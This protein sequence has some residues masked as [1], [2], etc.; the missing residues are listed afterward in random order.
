MG[1]RA[2]RE[3]TSGEHS[4]VCLLMI[5]KETQ[6]FGGKGNRRYTELTSHEK[7]KEVWDKEVYVLINV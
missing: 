3:F 2:G 1:Y 5:K 7:W 6:E 4:N